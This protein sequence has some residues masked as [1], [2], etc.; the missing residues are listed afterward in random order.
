MIFKQIEAKQSLEKEK[1]AYGKNIRRAIYLIKKS[2]DK[3][4]IIEEV[5]RVVYRDALE[6]CE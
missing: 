5:G 2:V 1:P 4:E 6:F 3:N